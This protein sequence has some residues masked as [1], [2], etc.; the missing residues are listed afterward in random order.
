MNNA[1]SVTAM[2]PV[3]GLKGY[4]YEKHAIAGFAHM[5]VVYLSPV[6]FLS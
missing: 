3:Q 1:L 5:K 4:Q 2:L 6:I